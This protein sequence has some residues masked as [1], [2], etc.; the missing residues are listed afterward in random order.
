MDAIYEHHWDSE[1]DRY[2]VIEP[3][4]DV[5]LTGG[6]VKPADDIARRKPRGLEQVHGYVAYSFANPEW[7]VLRLADG[8]YAVEYPFEIYLGNVRV[9]GSID[10]IIEHVPTGRLAVRDLKT[11][12]KLPETPLQLGVY[13]LAIEDDFGFRPSWGDFYMAK[14]NAP[15]EMYDLSHYTPSL[16]G[17]WFA[18]LERGI[19]NQV[20]I[21]NPG[22]ACRT[23]G[24]SK[25]CS[26]TGFDNTYQIGIDA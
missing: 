2:S 26:A 20:F 18:S 19:E 4:L 22:D 21:P 17:E 11:G 1:F 9:I 3:N 25:F 5:W 6:R 14:N 24:V 23:C 7:R 15:T 12:S 16:V 10:Q 13:D 8:D